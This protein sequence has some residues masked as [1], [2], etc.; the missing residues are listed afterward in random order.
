MITREITKAWSFYRAK[1]LKGVLF[2]LE[3]PFLIQFTK[4]G[5]CGVVSAIT[6]TLAVYLGEVLAPQ[7]FASH[8]T[9]QQIAWNTA[10]LHL[11]A[12][13]PSNCFTYALNRW[14]VFT[15]GRHSLGK[16]FTLFNII[17]LIS[18][19]LGEVIP[20]WLIN[21]SDLPRPAVHF[22]FIIAVAMINYVCRKF[23][24][25]EK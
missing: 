6:F 7:Y 15:S 21:N 10:I 4:Y 11:I 12:F 5:V 8:L 13:I 25:F 23:V 17:A 20:F 22:S 1:G 16:E 9:R 19:A 18:F 3:A 24:V 2:S 14:F